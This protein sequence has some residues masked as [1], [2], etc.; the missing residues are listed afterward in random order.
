[1]CIS[2]DLTALEAEIQCSSQGPLTTAAASLARMITAISCSETTR[3]L[4]LHA[5]EQ[6]V[7]LL[8]IVSLAKVLTGLILLVIPSVP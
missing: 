6:Q 4:L 5:A 1:M 8:A 3:L 7:K 2:A